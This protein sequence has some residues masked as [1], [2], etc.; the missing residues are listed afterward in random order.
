MGV[1]GFVL[2]PPA[3]AHLP[4]YPQAMGEQTDLQDIRAQGVKIVPELRCLNVTQGT[5][6]VVIPGNPQQEWRRFPFEGHVA[7]EFEIILW[8]HVDSVSGS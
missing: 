4:L 7:S 3:W 6:T 5:H 8:D 1:E 2:H